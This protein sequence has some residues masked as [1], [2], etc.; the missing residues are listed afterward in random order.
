[1]VYLLVNLTIQV[2][3]NERRKMEVGIN[4]R[5][6]DNCMVNKSSHVGLTGTSRRVGMALVGCNMAA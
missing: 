6:A 4:E 3:L 2:G 1:M 5:N